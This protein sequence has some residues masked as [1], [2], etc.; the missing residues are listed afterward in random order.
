MDARRRTPLLGDLRESSVG[1]AEGRAGH[2]RGEGGFLPAT[3]PQPADKRPLDSRA[4]GRGPPDVDRRQGNGGAGM[5]R[6]GVEDTQ[7]RKSFALAKVSPL[8][9]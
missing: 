1:R 3:A 7:I 6:V 8:T 2:P 9:L 5:T 4:Q